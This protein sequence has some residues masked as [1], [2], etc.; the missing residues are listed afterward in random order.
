MEPTILTVLPETGSKTIVSGIKKCG[1]YYRRYP[2]WKR[3]D[4]LKTARPQV[5]EN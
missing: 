3:N 1:V 4:D 2:M 5:E